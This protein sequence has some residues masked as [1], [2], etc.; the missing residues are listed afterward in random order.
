VR[1]GAADGGAQGH[2][3]DG[4]QEEAEVGVGEDFESVLYFFFIKMGI[5]WGDWWM[6]REEQEEKEERTK[7]FRA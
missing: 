7:E 4:G 6:G 2:E 3:R 5:S 1:D